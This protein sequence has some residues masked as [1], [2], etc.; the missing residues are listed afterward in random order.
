MQDD[1]ICHKK[2]FLIKEKQQQGLKICDT[3][4]IQKIDKDPRQLVNSIK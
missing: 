1:L 4:Q 2:N 3:T